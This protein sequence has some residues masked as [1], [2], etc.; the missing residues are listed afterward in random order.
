MFLFQIQRHIL[1]FLDQNS[2]LKYRL[3]SKKS[4]EIIDELY[5]FKIQI[6]T[7]NISDV[8]LDMSITKA[9]IIDLKLSTSS[10]PFLSKPER[11]T[12]LQIFGTYDVQMLLNILTLA[13]AIKR[14]TLYHFPGQNV[15][16]LNMKD[17]P[18]L[19][20]LQSITSLKLYNLRFQRRLD[21][22]SLG[23]PFLDVEYKGLRKFKLILSP[24]CRGFSEC[25]NSVSILLIHYIYFK[26][27]NII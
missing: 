22:T 19:Q 25:S 2:A 18:Q 6:N 1:S 20:T 12:A 26:F 13:T 15:D 7:S 3:V 27:E 11:L 14:F 10:M 4:K 8:H 17:T 21:M 24:G 9:T 5:N 23:A 16:L